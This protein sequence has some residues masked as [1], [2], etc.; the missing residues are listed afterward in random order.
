M[1][2]SL[3]RSRNVFS[4]VFDKYKH[5][6]ITLQLVS[7]HIFNYTSSNPM[8][9]RAYQILLISQWRKSKHHDIDE[10]LIMVSIKEENM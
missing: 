10:Y 2:F 1:C 3:I 7:V 8:N 6:F 9:T 5:M 4:C